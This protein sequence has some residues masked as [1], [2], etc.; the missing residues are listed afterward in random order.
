MLRSDG[1]TVNEM[2]LLSLMT[3]TIKIKLSVPTQSVSVLFRNYSTIALWWDG[4]A[5]GCNIYLQLDTSYSTT[6]IVWLTHA[7]KNVLH[8]TYNF[9]VILPCHA[10][11]VHPNYCIFLQIIRSTL[12]LYHR[13]LRVILVDGQWADNTA[14]INCGCVSTNIPSKVVL[15]K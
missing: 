11:L 2:E 15:H 6:A 12:C 14:N 4:P 8:C 7:T 5:Y 3:A 9:I 13:H 10:N 1:N